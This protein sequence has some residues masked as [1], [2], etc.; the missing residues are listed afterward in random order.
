MKR[1]SEPASLSEQIAA[2][3]E[4]VLGDAAISNLERLSGGASRETWSFSAGDRE[5]VLRRDPP[6]RPGAPGSMARE[7]S[8]IRAAH[9]AGLSVPAV[10]AEDDGELLGTAGLVMARVPGETIARRILRDPEFR[11]ARSVLTRQIGAFLGGLH[12]IDPGEVRGLAADDQLESYWMVYQLVGDRSLTFEAAYEWLAANRPPPP[13][14]PAIVHG[15]LRLGNLIVGP[16]G[17][18]AVIDWELVHLGDALEDL[19]WLCTKAWR[20]GEAMP[21][22]G[23]GSVED[24]FEAYSSVSGSAVDRDAFHWWLVLGTLKWGIICMGQAATHLSGAFRSVELAAIGRRVAEQEWDLLELLAPDEW[25]RARDDVRDDEAPDVPGLHGRPTARELLEA[26]QEFL[27]DQVMPS[28]GGQLSFHARVAANALAI[29][30]REL[31]S[32]AAQ[33]ARAA[34]SGAG[35][36]GEPPGWAALASVVRDKLAVAN[37]RHLGR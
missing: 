37:P 32:G 13:S 17:L 25:A 35:G 33:A 7:A 8:A 18:R 31:A 36:A 14:Q 21:V 26:V 10:L 28:T 15:D 3:L 29:V 1:L 9:R 2:T 30:D 22:A 23:V 19:A 20:F 6:G 16:D 4:P 12:S 5:L 11:E 34:A 24:L 27:T